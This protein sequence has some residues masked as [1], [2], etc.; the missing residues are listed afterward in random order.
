MP[1]AV[2]RIS[3]CVEPSS[4]VLNILE[5]VY[6]VILALVFRLRLKATADQ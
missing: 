4:Q 2:R 1:L 5:Y 6:G 3:I